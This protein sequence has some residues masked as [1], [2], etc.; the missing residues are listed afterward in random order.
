MLLNDYQIEARKTATYRT[1][2]MYPALGLA[3]ESGELIAKIDDGSTHEAIQGEIGDVLWYVSNVAYD[4]GLTLTDVIGCDPS[5]AFAAMAVLPTS[6]DWT[7]DLAIAVGKVCE[8]VK[9]TDRDDAGVL[10]EERQVKIQLGLRDVLFL[11][12]DI[13]FECSATL[14]DVAQANLDKLASRKVRG[15]LGGDGD[16]R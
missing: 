8:V 12:Q 7:E 3:G 16:N 10:T 5:S 13:S 9:K 2:L 6:D 1:P 4:A 11:M 15:V 14:T